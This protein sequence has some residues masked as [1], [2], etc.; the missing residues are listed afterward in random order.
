MENIDN[1]PQYKIFVET[2]RASGD[3]LYFIYKDRTKSL[4]PEFDFFLP[5]FLTRTYE[6][7]EYVQV[8]KDETIIPIER[9]EVNPFFIEFGFFD[10]IERNKVNK[11]GNLTSVMIDF[12]R[13]RRPDVTNLSDSNVRKWFDE[14]GINEFPWNKGTPTET[15]LDDIDKVSFVAGHIV[16]KANNYQIDVN[17]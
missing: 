1:I 5:L 12:I 10:S 7:Y 14:I 3:T 16:S 15:T 11:G 9:Q 2:E 17:K 13:E 6:I 4:V 8:N